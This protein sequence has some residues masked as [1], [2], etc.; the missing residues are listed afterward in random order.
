MTNKI[1]NIHGNDVME[2]VRSLL[3]IKEFTAC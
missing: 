3:F 1:K 2:G